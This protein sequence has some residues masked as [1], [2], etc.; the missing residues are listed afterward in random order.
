MKL[1]NNRK[2]MNIINSMKDLNKNKIYNQQIQKKKGLH[3][4]F[5]DQNCHL[6]RFMNEQNYIDSMLNTFSFV[7]VVQLNK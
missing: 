4:A 2:K 1:H 5:F 3:L 7:N 6:F